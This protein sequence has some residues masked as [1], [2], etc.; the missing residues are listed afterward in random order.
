MLGIKLDSFKREVWLS[1]VRT[2][3]LNGT[4]KV[5]SWVKVLFVIWIKFI[6][7]KCINHFFVI[8]NI[9]TFLILLNQS[10]PLLKREGAF[11]V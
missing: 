3:P 5:I 1:G 7:I 10:K 8:N 6:Q 11:F 4:P 2:S 9:N